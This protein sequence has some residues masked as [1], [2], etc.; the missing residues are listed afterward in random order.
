MAGRKG[1]LSGVST[2]GQ[3]GR[4]RA[5]LM[6]GRK[7]RPRVALMADPGATLTAGRTKNQIALPTKI[8]EQ[9][10]ESPMATGRH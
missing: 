1:H 2:V 8:L 5:A 10:M 4:L 7:E 3:K 6:A 9:S